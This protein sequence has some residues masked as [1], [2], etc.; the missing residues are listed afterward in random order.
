MKHVPYITIL[1]SLAALFLHFNAEA[2]E[3]LQWDR[4]AINS[5]EFWRVFAGHLTHWTRSHFIWGITV[6]TFIGGILEAKARGGFVMILALTPLLSHLALARFSPYATYRGLSAIDTSFFAYSLLLV[7]KHAHQKNQ[8]YTLAACFVVL[9]CF[10]AKLAYELAQQT[11]VFAGSLGTEVS[12]ATI[13]HLA[14]FLC[15][16]IALVFN[17][18][19]IGHR[20]RTSKTLSNT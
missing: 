12:V 2:T 8:K 10:I 13:T 17:L 9:V 6:F 19:A 3:A 11:P 15:A 5:G 16:C 7:A 14:G 4:N 1:L 20:L 18:T